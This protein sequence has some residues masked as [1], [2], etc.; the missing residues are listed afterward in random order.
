MRWIVTV[1]VI[2]LAVAIPASGQT[3]APEPGRNQ[4]VTSGSGRVEVPPDQ[5]ALSVGG[6]AQRPTAA[7]AMNDVNRIAAQVLARWQQLGVRR[8]DIRTSAIQV[9][10]VYTSPRDGSAPQLAGYRASYGLTLTT[11]NLGLIGRAIDAATAGGAN[12]VQGITFGLR[13]ATKARTEALTGAVRQAREKAEAIA[14]AAGLKIRGIERIVE[15]GVELQ[16]R[17][18]TFLRAPPA[19]TP[20]EPGLVTVTARVTIVFSY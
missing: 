20:V 18:V 6:E 1:I 15:E 3:P 7:E 4:I 8:E 5:A 12:T 19:P 13:D 9:S 17:E 2:L 11:T 16:A 10:P 14:Q